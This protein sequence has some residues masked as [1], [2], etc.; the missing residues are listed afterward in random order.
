MGIGLAIFIG[1][2][3]EYNLGVDGD[4]AYPGSIFL[5]AGVGLLTGFFI[6][7]KLDKEE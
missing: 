5:M 6:T 7:K 4:I 2:F 3:M 1:S